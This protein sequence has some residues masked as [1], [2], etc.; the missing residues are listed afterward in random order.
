MNGIGRSGAGAP[1]HSI[2]GDA[3]DPA[4]QANKD[5][6]FQRIYFYLLENS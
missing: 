5:I 6:I 3:G 1:G 2:P 4:V